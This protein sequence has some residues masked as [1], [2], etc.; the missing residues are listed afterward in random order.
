VAW[1]SVGEDTVR[2]YSA[3]LRKITQNAPRKIPTYF[4]YL[5]EQANVCADNLM[6][7]FLFFVAFA[8]V[9]S[10]TP[11]SLQPRTVAGHL[12]GPRVCDVGDLFSSKR[13]GYFSLPPL[14]KG[15]INLSSAIS[16]HHSRKKKWIS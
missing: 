6:E 15:E 7:F 10:S 13:R 5:Y 16:L 3:C 11:A 4:Q 2:R 14:K 8:D 9:T 1:E 12:T